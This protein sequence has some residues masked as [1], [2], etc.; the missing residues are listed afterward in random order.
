MLPNPEYRLNRGIWLVFGECD[1]SQ[2]A[3]AWGRGAGTEMWENEKL[4]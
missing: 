4:N 1:I 2:G 3:I